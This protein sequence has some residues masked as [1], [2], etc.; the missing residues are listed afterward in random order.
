MQDYLFVPVFTT[1]KINFREVTRLQ[2]HV[3][4]S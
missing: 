4:L 3:A 1:I 2:M